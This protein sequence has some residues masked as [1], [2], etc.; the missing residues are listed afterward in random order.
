MDSFLTIADGQGSA[1]ARPFYAKFMSKL[2]KSDIA[3][4]DPSIRFT[5]PEGDLGIVLDCSQ[6]QETGPSGIP[7]ESV[8]TEFNPN[9][10]Q[11]E[12]QSSRTPA[13]N[14]P[15]K[16]PITP[17]PKKKPKAIDDGFGG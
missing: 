15:V 4:Y 5:Q 13:S 9:R 6:Y 17:Q 12:E 16:A 1:M 7:T 2:E 3:S 11:D 10:F 14:T 8:P